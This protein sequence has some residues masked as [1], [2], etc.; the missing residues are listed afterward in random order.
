MLV[1]NLLRIIVSMLSAEMCQASPKFFFFFFVMRKEPLSMTQELSK[2]MQWPNDH[3]C[4]AMLD[5]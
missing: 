1:W 4:F 5:P 3:A 2:S